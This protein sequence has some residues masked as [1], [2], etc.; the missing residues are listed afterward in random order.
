VKILVINCGSSSIKAQLIDIEQQKCIIKIT[1]SN[2]DDYDYE[3][4]QVFEDIGSLDDISMFAHRVVHGGK[5]YSEATI[6]NDEVIKYIEEVSELAPLHNPINL[7][8]IY[9][10]RDNIKSAKQVA[11]FDTAFHNSIPQ[12]A[13]IYALPYEFYELYNIKKY[14]FHGTSHKYLSLKGADIL[15]QD[16]NKT[17]L[18]TLHLGNGASIC[19]IKN[20]KSIDTSMGFTPLE[21]LVMGTRSGDIDPQIIF[22]LE[23]NKSLSFKEINQILN[24]RSGL[25]GIAS[26][27]S[28]E[29][30]EELY[31][32]DDELAILALN[33]FA[34]RIKKYIGGFKEILNRVDGIIISGGIGEN[35]KLVRSLIF[36]NINDIDVIDDQEISNES[37]SQRIFV[38]KTNEELQIA[39]EAYKL[40]IDN[41]D[42][43]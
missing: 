30:L 20:G 29:E 11:V 23:E 5:K 37:S 22:W 16:I 42:M 1:K 21:G 32:Q 3:L 39:K 33:V 18:I 8:A 14:G 35:S 25:L 12:V 7:K 4:S 13:H 36:D 27:S 38:I 17:N 34:Y 28:V 6:I 26:H 41:L 15:S 2:V 10:I 24:K 9:Y 40:N 19:A 43:K 31:H